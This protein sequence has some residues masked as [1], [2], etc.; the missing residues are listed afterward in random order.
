MRK[1]INQTHL[2]GLLYQHSLSLKVSG[3]NSKNPGTQFINGTIDVATNDALTNIVTV[4]FSYVTPTYQKSGSA[5]ATFGVLQNIINGVTCNVIDHGADKAAKVRI[6]SQIGLNEFFS[7]RNG[8]EELVSVKRNE[9]GFIHVVQTIAATENLRDTFCADMIIKKTV[10]QEA[11]DNHPERMIISGYVFDFRN[12]LLPVDFMMYNPGGMDHFEAFEASEKN[13][14][15][16]NV[17]GHQVCQTVTTIQKGESNGWGESFAQ[18][19]TSTQREFVITGGKDPY[20]WDTEESITAIE[21][22]EKLQAREVTVAEIKQRQD[23]YNASR[24]QTQTPVAAA[25]APN[26]FNF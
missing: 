2:E 9:G 23:E 17:N 3:E 16:V 26:G 10:R 1:T 5:N 11:T 22:K 20:D 14:V 8:T 18:E 12:S 6:D 25:G 13:P 21:Y 4:H 19:V 15:F 24:A 7:N